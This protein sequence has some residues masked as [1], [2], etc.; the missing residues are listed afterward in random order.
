M[1]VPAYS[2]SGGVPTRWPTPV[3]NDS[4]SGGQREGPNVQPGVSLTDAVKLWPTPAA[5]DWK[6]TGSPSEFDRKSP[7]LLPSVLRWATP[8]A[9]DAKGAPGAGTLARGGRERDLPTML[10]RLN[11]AFVEAL[12]GFPPDWTLPAAEESALTSPPSAPGAAGPQ[13]RRKRRTNGSR[14]ARSKR[15]GRTTTRD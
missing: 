9:H 4:R 6:D 15:A 1:C 11:P 7:C 10:P 14:P 2:S 3:V 8:Q 12:Q 5:R 13:D